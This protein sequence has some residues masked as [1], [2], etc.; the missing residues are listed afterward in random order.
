MHSLTVL[1]SFICLC[2]EGTLTKAPTDALHQIAG[3]AP[4]VDTPVYEPYKTSLGEFF[5][6]G[7]LPGDR[8][9]DRLMTPRKHKGSSTDQKWTV[10][11]KRE[12]IDGCNLLNMNS[13]GKEE[14]LQ[15]N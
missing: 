12:D 5:T 4:M 13:K 9:T 8:D 14:C 15:L 2:S 6:V 1:L 11:N 7:V 10:S 3:L